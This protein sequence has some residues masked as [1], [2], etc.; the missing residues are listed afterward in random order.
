MEENVS[1]AGDWTH[2]CAF[3]AAISILRLVSVPIIP[4]TF[5]IVALAAVTTISVTLPEM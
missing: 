1:Q 4:T 5:D 3:T 2:H